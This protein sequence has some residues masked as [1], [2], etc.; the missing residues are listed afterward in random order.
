MAPRGPRFLTGHRGAGARGAAETRTGRVHRAL[1][2][3]GEDEEPGGRRPPAHLPQTPSHAWAGRVMAL[4]HDTPTVPGP[5]LPTGSP[6]EPCSASDRAGREARGHR[7]PVP[8]GTPLPRTVRLGP[9]SPGMP[10]APPGGPGRR[11]ARG[12]SFTAC[13]RGVTRGTASAWGPDDPRG[14]VDRS[15][16]RHPPRPPR[17]PGAADEALPR[18]DGPCHRHSEQ[19]EEEQP[20][21]ERPGKRFDLD[22]RVHVEPGEREPSVEDSRHHR[23]GGGRPQGRAAPPGPWIR[24]RRFPGRRDP[25]N[26]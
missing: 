26:P 22:E 2:S 7:D 13:G 21:H 24:G 17:L 23:R 18:Q 11:V 19:G 10:A 12:S 8:S 15:R 20:G 25:R 14:M 4:V 1:T 16:L 5:R 6:E 3:A 9:F